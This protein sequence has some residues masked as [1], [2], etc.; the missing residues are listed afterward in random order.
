MLGGFVLQSDSQ[1]ATARM[2][3]VSENKSPS[4]Q[5]RFHVVTFQHPDSTNPLPSYVLDLLQSDWRVEGIHKWM[6]L[7]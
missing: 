7:R 6:K 4:R 2:S 3:P 1:K 5:A